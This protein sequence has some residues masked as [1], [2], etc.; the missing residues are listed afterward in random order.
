[1]ISFI[2]PAY[3]AEKY[4]TR[5]IESI[6]SLTYEKYEIIV[7]ND[8]SEDSTLEKC[9][10]ITNSHMVVLTQEN[11]GVS[12]A[13]NYGLRYASGEYVIFVDADDT[14]NKS[15]FERVIRYVNTNTVNILAFDYAEIYGDT[16]KI[17]VFPKKTG[18]YGK[19][20]CQAIRNNLIDFPISENKKSFYMGAKVYQYLIR[21]DMLDDICFPEGIHYAEDLCFFRK[22][23]EKTESIDVIHDCAYNYYIYNDSAAH[24]YRKNYWQELMA[25][26][27]ILC[28]NEELPEVK[29]AYIFESLTHYIY[30]TP[31]KKIGELYHNI[32]TVIC[33][34]EITD[35]LSK[36]KYSNWSN[37][38]IVLQRCIKN[39]QIVKFIIYSQILRVR[40][41]IMRGRNK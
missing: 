28:E 36:I 38:E 11:K 39:R 18:V 16:R 6:L 1:M 5:C 37:N 24:K 26:Y 15:G 34:V 41:K 40:K 3:N 7:V 35:I 8:G 13:R 32:K 31:A 22:V 33:S 14:I 2:I 21:K 30:R 27:N 19:E 25:V 4:I 29:Y 10:K 23:F 17:Q 20:D 9:N 12:A